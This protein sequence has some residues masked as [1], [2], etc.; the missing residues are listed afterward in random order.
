[1]QLL[2]DQTFKFS[3]ASKSVG[4]EV[5]NAGKI[6]EKDFEVFFNLWGNGGPLW[7]REE[8]LFYQ[9]QDAE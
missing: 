2:K 9:E 4:F 3:V 1:M 8:R 5:Y 7:L 6:V